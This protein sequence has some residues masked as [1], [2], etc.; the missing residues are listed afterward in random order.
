M[1]NAL[2]L[3]SVCALLC[4]ACS[5]DSIGPSDTQP[6]VQQILS[7][8]R[9]KYHLPAIAGVYIDG[10]NTR[11]AVAGVRKNGS[12]SIAT[13]DD[14]WH[15][16][17]NVK[18]MSATMI[19]TIVEEGKLA[20]SSTIAEI[21]PELLPMM[22]AEYK[23]VTLAMLLNHRGGIFPVDTDEELMALPQWPGTAVEQRRAFVQWAVEKAPA[24]A[25]GAYHYSNGGY[26]LAAAMAEKATGQAW[27]ALMEQRLFAPLGIH[28]VFAWPAAGGL[29][30]PWGHIEGTSG[31]EP[32]DP[33]G[34]LQF[35]VA[36][37]PAGHCSLSLG[38]YTLFAREHLRGLRGE[39]AL[40]KKETFQF[41][42][43]PVGEYAAGWSISAVGGVATHW[44]EGSD[45]TFDAMIVLQPDRNKA[46]I[47][48]TNCASEQAL[49]AINDACLLM[50]K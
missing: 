39:S 2:F 48:I 42:H 29:P 4:V 50:L 44:H 49:V 8:Q 20:W 33:D 5:S 10:A 17:S 23:N 35:P 32:F 41:L 46:A 47:A 13:I 11:K 27:E 22:K 6:N 30:Q 31:Y 15:I 43:T 37:I 25:P 36:L 26:I 14:R 7:A 1:V 45:G 12:S 3:I 19:A 34:E 24:T 18:A 21:F 9:E 16:G 40:L 28:P 38:D